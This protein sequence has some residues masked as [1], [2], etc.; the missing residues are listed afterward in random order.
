MGRWTALQ[1]KRTMPG[2][3]VCLIDSGH[4]VT[5]SWGCTRAAHV[6]MEDEVLLRMALYS[7]SQYDNLQPIARAEHLPL[8]QTTGRLT[9]G[10]KGTLDAI[11]SL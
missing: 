2:S 9:G 11:V 7:Y 1:L 4:S 10:P 6:H 3:K 5:G 8:F